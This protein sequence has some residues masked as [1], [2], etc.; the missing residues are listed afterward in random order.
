MRRVDVH[1]VVPT[2]N[3]IIVYR[4]RRHDGDR[5]TGPDWVEACERAFWAFASRSVGR[6]VSSIQ[7]EDRRAIMLAIRQR[8]EDAYR[9]AVES[10][11]STP[12]STAVRAAVALL[13]DAVALYYGARSVM[14]RADGGEDVQGE[15]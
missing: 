7:G 9:R 13:E 10:A 3:E 8:A 6:R 5:M 11:S 12:G 4:Q 2:I 15:S 14:M 1:D